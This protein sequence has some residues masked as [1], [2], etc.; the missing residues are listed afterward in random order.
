MAS[1]SFQQPSLDDLRDYFVP[2][3]GSYGLDSFE[4]LHHHEA[5]VH[6]DGRSLG[7]LDGGRWVGG[8]GAFSFEVTLP[9][10]VQVPAAGITMIGVAATHHRRG[11]G[12]HVLEWLH[13]DAVKRGEVMAVLTASE[14]SI[15]RRFGYGVAT[16]STSLAV[17]CDRIV[18]DPPVIDRGTL[19]SVDLHADTTLLDAVYD[20]ARRQRTGNF[21]RNDDWWARVRHDPRYDRN[22]ASALRAVAHVD[23]I[24]SPDG[25]VT[26]RVRN[27]TSDARNADNTLI[28]DELVGLTPDVEATL[29]SF[30]AGIDLATTVEWHNAPTDA[31]WRWRLVEPRQL[32][33]R[34]T[35]DWMWAHLLDIPAVLSTRRYRAP[36]RLVLSVTDPSHP[37]TAGTF[38]LT[39]DGAPDAVGWFSGRCER[40]DTAPRASDQVDLTL[41]VADLSTMA[42]GAVAPSLL[43]AAGKMQAHAASLALADTLFVSHQA[44]HCPRMF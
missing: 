4:D 27:V 44:A 17:P 11:I 7:A 6:E 24:G 22:G 12:R 31:A 13:D 15:Y 33:R 1:H 21:A 41:D 14:S 29:W 30:L 23:D 9:G 5:L 2:I 18:F 26:W 20:R 25:Y 38:E 28:I 40:I 16:E 35:A 42:F 10:D 8:G 37:A 34:L 39:V 43:A 3:F 19:R 32:H 36:G